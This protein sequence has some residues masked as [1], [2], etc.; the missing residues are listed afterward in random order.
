M[1]EVIAR[2]EDQQIRI[3]LSVDEG[4]ALL[5]EL[6]ID[7]HEVLSKI[8]APEKLLELVCTLRALTD[9]PLELVAGPA[10]RDD[11]L[12]PWERPDHG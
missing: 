2:R 1:V 11:A 3:V 5:C 4:L 8:L 6:G 10:P 12:T 9:I 7:R